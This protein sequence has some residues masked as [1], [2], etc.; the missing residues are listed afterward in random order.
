MLKD[1]ETY[2]SL[3]IETLNIM[4]EKYLQSFCWHSNQISNYVLQGTLIL[5]FI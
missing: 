1:L 4:G 2:A 3:G 5:I